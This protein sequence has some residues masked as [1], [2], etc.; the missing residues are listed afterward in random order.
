MVE[1]LDGA[2]VVWSA[3]E[4]VRRRQREKES[5]GSSSGGGGGSSSSGGGEGGNNSID[6]TS[7]KAGCLHKW[8]IM[9]T[10]GPYCTE[11]IGNLRTT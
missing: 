5:G 7:S 10:P 3:L 1:A 6:T 9:P 8:G 2:E 11:D 4:V